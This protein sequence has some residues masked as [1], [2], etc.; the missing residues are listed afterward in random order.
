[1]TLRARLGFLLLLT[2]GFAV[3][4]VGPA[5]QALEQRQAIETQ[6]QKLSALRSANAGL[7]NRLTR[8][9]DREYLEKA[10][11][12]QLGL[13]KPGEISYIVERPPAPDRPKAPPVQPQPWYR[14]AW[15]WLISKL[16]PV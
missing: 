2:A 14:K 12:E 13:V 7:E 15:D 11:R 5:R 10:A 1:M 16:P 4:A 6:E 9:S 3:A 8:L